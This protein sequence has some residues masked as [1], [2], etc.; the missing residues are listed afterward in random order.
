MYNTVYFR[1]NSSFYEGIK[2]KPIEHLVVEVAIFT[3][4][5]I[6]EDNIEDR[7]PPLL[8]PSFLKETSPIFVMS[9]FPYE[10]VLTKEIGLLIDCLLRRTEKSSWKCL[11]IVTNMQRQLM[12]KD[13]PFQPNL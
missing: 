2:I 7:V 9:L 6:E 10:D 4:D 13:V 12:Q 1:C 11:T 5:N 3:Q 8:W